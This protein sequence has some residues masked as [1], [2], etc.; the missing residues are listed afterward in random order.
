MVA[1]CRGLKPPSLAAIGVV[2]V[3][4]AAGLLFATSAHTAQG[5]QLRTDRTDLMGLIGSEEARREARQKRVQDLRADVD[6][7]TKAEATV[8]TSVGALQRA[9][10]RLAP[11]AGLEPVTGPGLTVRLNDAPHGGTQA[12]DALPDDLVVHQQDVQSVVNALW[13]GGAEA[14][15]LMDQRVISTSAVRCVGNTLILQGRVYSPP[16]EI[17]AIGDQSKMRQKLG[18]SPAIGIYLEYVQRFGLGWAVE[19]QSRLV[20]PAYAGPLEM[21]FARAAGDDG[22]TP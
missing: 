22:V 12:T 1:A 15:M 4:V 20:L 14:M 10:D 3:L 13:A 2:L 9:V 16:Y 8:N 6:A 18:E 21:R 19:Y 11:I 7:Q 5:T 17:T